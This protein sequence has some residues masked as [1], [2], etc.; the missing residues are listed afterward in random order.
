M[1]LKKKCPY[2]K[3]KNTICKAII[4]GKRKKLFDRKDIKGLFDWHVEEGYC[5]NEGIS[6]C[7]LSSFRSFRK[8]RAWRIA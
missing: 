1:K 8:N 3:D 5:T 4:I 2:F 7:P 6:C